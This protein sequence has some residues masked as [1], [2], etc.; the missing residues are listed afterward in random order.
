MIGRGAAPLSGARASTPALNNSSPLLDQ[1]HFSGGRDGFDIRIFQTQAYR[2]VTVGREREKFALR[3]GVRR[4]VDDSSLVGSE[5]GR[6]DE[7][8][9]KRELTIAR[10]RKRRGIHANDEQCH[11]HKKDAD[12][13]HQG[14]NEPGFSGFWRGGCRCRHQLSAADEEID[15][16]ASNAKAMSRAD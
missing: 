9:P 11:G 6:R 2:G 7:L 3:P 16:N 8:V 13:S 10:R 5:P 12:H 14:G 15:D 4:A 1:E